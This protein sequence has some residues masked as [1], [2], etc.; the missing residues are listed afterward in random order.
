[1]KSSVAKY[2]GCKRARHRGLIALH[3]VHQFLEHKSRSILNFIVSGNW[4]PE[5]LTNI[6]W[7]KSAAISIG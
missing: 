5:K 1:M 7:S 3:V 6:S 2:Y 4:V